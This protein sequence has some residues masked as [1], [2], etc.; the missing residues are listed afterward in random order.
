MRT[1]GTSPLRLACCNLM[2]WLTDTAV[3]SAA[4]YR[5]PDRIVIHPQ[6]QT[7]AGFWIADR[8]ITSILPTT[9]VDDLGLAALQALRCSRSRLH[10][11]NYKGADW[12]NLQK[13]VWAATGQ[14]SLRLFMTNA[15]YANLRLSGGVLTFE[16]TCNG[17]AVGPSC[18]FR[19][20]LDVTLKVTV[21]VC[22]ETL[23]NALATAWNRCQPI[24][25]GA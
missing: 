24:A 21:P 11:P 15:C 1:G 13:E 3:H 20:L 12:S 8:P 9:T 17:G 14:K 25:A 5:W 7:T 18:G 19:P 22:A 16:P 10:V 23:G 2:C 6:S 4:A